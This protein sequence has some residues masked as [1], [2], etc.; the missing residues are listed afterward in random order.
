MFCFE[1]E[2]KRGRQGREIGENIVVSLRYTVFSHRKFAGE[3]DACFDDGQRP[4]FM[5]MAMCVIE[6]ENDK[7]E[8][9]GEKILGAMT[10]RMI[11]HSHLLSD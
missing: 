8:W 5:C 11:C 6:R 9:K 7:R 2:N 3:C 4:M 10:N 1:K